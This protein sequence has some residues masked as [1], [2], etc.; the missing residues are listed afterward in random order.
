MSNLNTTI[1]LMHGDKGATIQ[2]LKDAFKADFT[3]YIK[4]NAGAL[5]DAR[6]NLKNGLKDKAIENAITAG[7]QAG[8][9]A[10]YIAPKGIKFDQQPAE[11][12]AMWQNHITEA[13]AA[14]DAALDASDAWDKKILTDAEKQERADKKA[15]KALEAANAIIA[16][17]GLVDPRSVRP[18][19]HVEL[20]EQAIHTITNNECDKA[21]LMAVYTATMTAL[22]IIHKAEATTLARANMGKGVSSESQAVELSRAIWAGKAHIAAD[23]TITRI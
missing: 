14:F 17:K 10:Y 16:Q 12:L 18:F 3:L 15:T 8:G 7:Q 9:K 6:L 1:M 21:Q 20:I 23:G 4:G 13:C 22:S 5:K 2:A 19:T 11:D